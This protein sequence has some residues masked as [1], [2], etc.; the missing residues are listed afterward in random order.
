MIA[1]RDSVREK[2]GC[3]MS[4]SLFSMSRDEADDG[5]E[6]KNGGMVAVERENKENKGWSRERRRGI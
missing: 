2:L 3:G 1:Q 4:G 5:Y 6:R